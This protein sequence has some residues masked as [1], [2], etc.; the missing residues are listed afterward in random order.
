MSRQ[1]QAQH[2]LCGHEVG[3]FSTVL[4][5]LMMMLSFVGFSRFLAFSPSGFDCAESFE[6]PLSDLLAP[7]GA[8]MR[9]F[10]N[11]LCLQLPNLHIVL[12][13]ALLACLVCTVSQTLRQLVT[14]VW[15]PG[16]GIVVGTLWIVPTG[17]LRLIW[18]QHALPSVTAVA[19]LVV[20]PKQ[21]CPGNVVLVVSACVVGR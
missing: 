3:Q 16:V 12:C 6:Y 5:T 13:T 4:I 15:V 7:Q 19:L 20:Q 8:P 11:G 9:G 18:N 17:K 21:H 1:D 14:W 10:V 2:L